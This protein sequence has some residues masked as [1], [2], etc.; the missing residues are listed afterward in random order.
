MRLFWAALNM[1]YALESHPLPEGDV[2]HLP[3]YS[4]DAT[5]RKFIKTLLQAML[6]APDETLAI[7]A[8]HKAVHKKNKLKLPG[9]ISST[10]R[11]DLIPAMNAIKKKHN[12]IERHFCSGLGVD[13]QYQI[14]RAHV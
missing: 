5:C 8:I 1:I 11:A 3:G 6:N 9:E 10:K 7:K 13:L 2:Y 14:G 12:K 4:N